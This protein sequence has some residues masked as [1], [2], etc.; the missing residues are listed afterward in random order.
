MTKKL[1]PIIEWNWAVGER[2]WKFWTSN[3]VGPIHVGILTVRRA[4][5][6]V[7]IA[8]IMRGQEGKRW[9]R[10]NGLPVEQA[11]SFAK[12]RMESLAP[13]GFRFTEHDFSKMQSEDEVEYYMREMTEWR[14]EGKEGR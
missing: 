12:E 6:L 7:D 14:L 13:K 1:K 10:D 5:G 2:P 3:Q 8:F 4:N 9:A 11:E